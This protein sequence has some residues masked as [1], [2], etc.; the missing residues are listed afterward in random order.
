MKK[1][2]LITAIVLTVAVFFFGQTARIPESEKEAVIKTG[3]DYGDGFYSGVASRMERALFPDLNKVVTVKLPQSGKTVLQ[4]SMVSELIELS[5]AK[6]GFL[7]ED[8]R[9]TKVEVLDILDNIAIA[10]LTSAYFDDYLAMIKTDGQ[11]KIVNVLWAPGPDT[12]N[13]KPIEGFD[14]AKETPDVQAAAEEYYKGLFTGDASLLEKIIHP[15][16]RVAQAG[17]IPGSGKAMINRMGAGMHVEIVRA[18]LRVVPEDKQHVEIHVL[19]LMDGMAFVKA[20]TPS[21]TSFLQMQLMD[22]QWRII[23]ILTQRT[24]AGPAAR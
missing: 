2:V 21:A 14:P 18:K 3:L 20:V 10:K 8:K 12:P 5:R 1:T 19:D 9:K 4:Y 16:T 22:G 17:F 13:R 15:E 23:N 6:A 11:W 7:P 24:S